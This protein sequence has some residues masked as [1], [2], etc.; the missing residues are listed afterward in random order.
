MLAAA[1]WYEAREPG[2]WVQHSLPNWTPYS[3]LSDIP[4]VLRDPRKST[5][6]KER[7]SGAAPTNV[8]R[9]R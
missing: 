3:S 1:N 7:W 2:G 8:L 6:L 4:V 5:G 9:S